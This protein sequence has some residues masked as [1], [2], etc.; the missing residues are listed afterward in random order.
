MSEGPNCY[1][2]EEYGAYE[3][4]ASLNLPDLPEYWVRWDKE[5]DP[6]A[7]RT[8]ETGA[9]FGD[10]YAAGA[11]KPMYGNGVIVNATMMPY[12]DFINDYSRATYCVIT[13]DDDG[14]TYGDF[15]EY[16]PWL[17]GTANGGYDA[18]NG[19]WA[20]YTNYHF[21]TRCA[22]DGARFVII[23]TIGS[24]EGFSSPTFQEIRVA[25][26]VNGT[27]WTVNDSSTANEYIVGA[28]AY[29]GDIW[30]LSNNG[31]A[32]DLGTEEVFYRIGYSSNDGVS[33]S[34]TDLGDDDLTIGWSD[35][36]E[37]LSYLSANSSGCHVV[38]EI[39][40]NISGDYGQYYWRPTG[41]NTWAAPIMLWDAQTDWPG[42][43]VAAAD[44]G[45][46]LLACRIN[47][48]DLILSA[49]LDWNWNGVWI[50]RS[51]DGGINWSAHQ[52]LIELDEAGPYS[53]EIKWAQAWN[54][55]QLVELDDG[56]LVCVIV[57][58]AYYPGYETE[59]EGAKDDWPGWTAYCVS[60]DGGATWSALTL[61]TP[62]M[63]SDP[64]YYGQR[65]ECCAKGV[66]VVVT[67][68]HRA[69]GTY[70]I[71]FRPTATPDVAYLRP[72]SM[73]LPAIPSSGFP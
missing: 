10:G 30:F 16:S 19:N 58:N 7:N 11:S 67:I 33:W 22:W 20:P 25:Y 45:I 43:S 32:N 63:V 26:S 1:W 71:I 44:F 70:N 34:V 59:A 5:L 57:Y 18:T 6:I 53:E 68:T 8:A 66:D 52:L 28:A 46:A 39:Y 42:Y 60:E 40:H 56:R 3:I 23:N 9:W 61:V 69:E 41:V 62:F 36:K 29:A 73:V 31:F 24:D 13:S 12:G 72:P 17:Q 49:Q 47:D 55:V 37:R 48:P 14:F 27:D 35:P 2:I 38:G 65:F 4:C 21:G 54:P 64:Y 51:T 50:R 15:I